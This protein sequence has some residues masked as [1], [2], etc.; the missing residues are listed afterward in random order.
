[1]SG[2]WG[3]RIKY[4]I[5][6]E[7][8]GNKIG[9]TIHGLPAGILID[10]CKID[11]DLRRRS[12]MGKFYA[13]DRKEMDEYKIISGFLNGYTTGAPLTVLFENKDIRQ[14]DYSLLDELF[15]PG[16]SDYSAFIK[17]KNF[18]DKAGG[19]HFSGRITASL[20]F[21]GAIAKQLL[22][23]ITIVSHILSIGDIQDISLL[24]LEITE[25]ILYEYLKKDFPVS[26]LEVEEKM[27]DKILRA[28]GEGDSVG[29]VIETIIYGIPAGIGE[30]FFNS[31]E[32]TISSLVFSIPAIKGI[33][34]GMGFDITK[35]TGKFAND[36]MKIEDEKFKFCSNNNGGI[37]GGIS[38]GMPIVFKVAV[39]PT[40][41]ISIPQKTINYK[42]NENAT[43]E[44]SG[45]HDPCIVPRAVVVVESV[46]AMSILD[47]IG[48]FN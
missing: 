1:M 10:F 6:G 21:A 41:S 44:L 42:I 9:I 20:V 33:E 29:G 28:K 38:N 39:K 5:F 24:N 18:N 7:S 43:I 11:N 8:H 12:S 47:L 2:V 22:G 13:T 34:F 35:L 31:V 15:R 36:E 40:S 14:K 16:H 17:Y 23:G 27:L 32:S 26:S 37:L 25:D 4:S 19:G 30:P 48:G 45:R 46:S 3:N